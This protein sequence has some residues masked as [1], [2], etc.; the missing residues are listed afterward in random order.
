MPATPAFEYTFEVAAGD[1]ASWSIP[2]PGSESGTLRLTG[3]HFNGIHGLEIL[4]HGLCRTPP[5]SVPSGDVLR[6]APITARSWPP[7]GV[8]IVALGTDEIR[9]Q[10]D[11]LL[12]LVVGFKRTDAASPSG[13]TSIT[14]TYESSDGSYQVL[15]PWSITLVDRGDLPGA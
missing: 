14:L 11:P 12:D 1:T 8:E 4:G 13:W 6:C 2:L 9:Q 3:V 10:L 5:P 7:P 15:E